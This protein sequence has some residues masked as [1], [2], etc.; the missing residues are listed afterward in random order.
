MLSLATI[1][2]P[3][4]DQSLFLKTI[5]IILSLGYLYV[6]CASIIKGIPNRISFKPLLIIKKSI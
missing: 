1:S 6:S 5:V 4:L 2:L 3:C